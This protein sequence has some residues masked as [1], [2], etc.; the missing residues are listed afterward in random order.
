[1]V[2]LHAD[3]SLLELMPA[4]LSLSTFCNVQTHV[5]LPAKNALPQPRQHIC[6]SLLIGLLPTAHHDNHR[7]LSWEAGQATEHAQSIENFCASAVDEA[8]QSGQHR[9]QAC[10]VS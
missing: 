2:T 8:G 7:L 5:G 1:M 6:L 10:H 9:Q 3:K 4:P